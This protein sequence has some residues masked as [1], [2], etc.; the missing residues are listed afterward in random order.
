MTLCIFGG[1]FINLMFPIPL[2][3]RVEMN[4]L[5]YVALWFLFQVTAYA[6][7]LNGHPNFGHIAYEAHVAGY[8]SGLA[9]GL[10][11][12]YVEAGARE[13]I[14]ERGRNAWGLHGVKDLEKVMEKYGER[15]EL[16]KD[17]ALRYGTFGYSRR[18]EGYYRKAVAAL[19]K[20]DMDSVLE[21]YGRLSKY[22]P[23]SLTPEQDL[24]I[25]RA[26]EKR[27]MVANAY[28]ALSRA[29]EKE[30]I[31]DVYRETA[32]FHMG[33]LQEKLGN[34]EGALEQYRRFLREFPASPLRDKVRRRIERVKISRSTSF[35][36]PAPPVPF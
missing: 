21:L 5:L 14:K 22:Y 23:F 13:M 19:L 6:R 9:L 18:G 29:A 20:S 11:L 15:P 26:Y 16:L 3:L 4:S 35:R 24:A 7:I 2:S 27:G 28:T 8:L 31:A 32:L 34:R 25:A 10:W 30:G 12:G 36:K 33:D 17:I 1:P